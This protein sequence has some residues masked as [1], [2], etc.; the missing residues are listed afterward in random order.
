[1]KKLLAVAALAILISTGAQAKVYN[2]DHTNSSIEFSGTHAG[3]NFKGKFGKWEAKVDFDPAK[4][5]NSKI[6]AS[7]ETASARTGNQMYDGTLP[8]ADWFN[9]E[10]FP[11]AKFVST[12]VK[13]DSVAGK[14][15]AAGNLTIRGITKPTT[16][17]FT[18]SD[19]SKTPL[20]ATGT[21]TI[22]R[23]AFDIGKKSDAGAEWVGKDIIVNITI[24]AATAN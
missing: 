21:L 8:Q 9:S 6:E 22:D 18:I 17:I 15:V 3:N 24:N 20:V 12:S 23:L 19:V 7:F 4:L 2:V 14:Y 1:M 16:I 13:A 11:N 5:A 10:N